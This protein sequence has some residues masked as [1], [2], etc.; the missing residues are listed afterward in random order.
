M[1]ISCGSTG[2]SAT[3]MQAG[4]TEQALA[5]LKKHFDDAVVTLMRRPAPVGATPGKAAEEVS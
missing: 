2:S 3:A 4:E 5:V 1:T